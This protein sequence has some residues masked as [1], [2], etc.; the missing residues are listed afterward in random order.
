MKIVFTEN[1][2]DDLTYWIEY[3]IIKLKKSKNLSIP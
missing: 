3:D 1:A 2:R